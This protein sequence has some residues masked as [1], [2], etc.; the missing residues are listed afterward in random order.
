V[1]RTYLGVL[2]YPCGHTAATV[3]VLLLASPQLARFTV[4]RVLIPE[5]ARVVVAVVAV[6]VMAVRFHYFTDT[7]AGAAV[8]TVSVCVLAFVLD[9]AQALF[10]RAFAAR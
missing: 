6:G 9:L 3:T 2:S 7:V 5:A 1:H 8:G 4:L 10:G